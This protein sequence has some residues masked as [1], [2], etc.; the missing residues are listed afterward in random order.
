VTKDA[1]PVEGWA[2]VL[3]DSAAGG[4]TRLTLE[5]EPLSP[6]DADRVEFAVFDSVLMRLG[7][8]GTM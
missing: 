6:A 1:P 7:P 4:S 3:S 5:F 8:P 2:R